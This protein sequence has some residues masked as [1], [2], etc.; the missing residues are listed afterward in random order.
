M[1]LQFIPPQKVDR[2]MRLIHTPNFTK[3]VSPPLSSIERSFGRSSGDNSIEKGGNDNVELLLRTCNDWRLTDPKDSQD[4]SFSIAVTNKLAGFTAATMDVKIRKNSG[5]QTF[6]MVVDCC[7]DAKLKEA[8]LGIKK[9]IYA[10]SSL[11][12]SDEHVMELKPWIVT[13]IDVSPELPQPIKICLF[14]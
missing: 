14:E 3:R 6:G 11:K 8:S 12:G 13:K 2:L 9:A 4:Q 7:Q 1:K 10:V 5:A